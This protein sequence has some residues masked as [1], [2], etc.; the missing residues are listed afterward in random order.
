MNNEA[1]IMNKCSENE[2]T[3]S[4]SG[5][6][7]S[8]VFCVVPTRFR[9]LRLFLVRF[10]QKH[11]INV[12]QMNGFVKKINLLILNNR[13]FFS[14]FFL[15]SKDK[16]CNQFLRPAT[17]KLNLRTLKGSACLA[18]SFNVTKHHSIIVS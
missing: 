10:L 7:F 6:F 3:C 4:S 1:K 15:A 17:C 14:P 18:L 2:H 16:K 8:I 11:E 12:K 9:F 5:A 13:L